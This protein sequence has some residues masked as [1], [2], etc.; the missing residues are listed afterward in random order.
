V[1]SAR[2]AALGLG[3]DELA[4]YDALETNDGAVKVLG[5]ETLRAIARG[6]VATVRAKVTARDPAPPTAAASGPACA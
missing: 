5:D 6:L 2:G 1:A 4:F 3:D